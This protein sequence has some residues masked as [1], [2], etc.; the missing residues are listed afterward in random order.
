MPKKK[1]KVLYASS[2]VVPFAKTGGLADVAGAL[3]KYLQPLGCDLKLV[4]PYYRM[5]KKTEV[6][7]RHLGGEME[8]TVGE[9]TIPVDLYQGVAT[10]G[11]FHFRSFNSGHEGKEQIAL[12]NDRDNLAENLIE[13][14]KSGKSQKLV[15]LK[16]RRSTI[17]AAFKLASVSGWSEAKTTL[18]ELESEETSFLIRALRQTLSHGVAFHN[19]DLTP[20]QRNAIEHGYRRGEIRVIFSTTTLAMG[21]NLPAE[22][23]LL[24]TMKYSADNSMVPMM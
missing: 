20:V 22:T 2:E 14:L 13:F 21:V 23:V 12:A 7:L 9:E 8:V 10:G 6:P 17:D 24:E 3:P 16:S 18:S 15:F 1:L 11:Y 4:M 19:A 5:V